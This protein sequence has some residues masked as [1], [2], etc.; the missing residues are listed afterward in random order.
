[1][2]NG[3]KLRSCGTPTDRRTFAPIPSAFF[4]AVKIFSTP[5]TT[6]MILVVLV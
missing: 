1:M 4:G 5:R 2:R 6:D 3:E